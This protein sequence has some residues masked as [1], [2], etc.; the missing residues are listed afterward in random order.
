MSSGLN[1]VMLLGEVAADPELYVT[2]GG[3]A[4]LQLRLGTTE[5]YLDKDD[6]RHERTWYHAVVVLNK[7]AHA[8]AKVLHRG[9]RIFVEG[10]LRTTTFESLE[11]GAKRTKTEV[12]ADEVLYAGE[13]G[14][15][16]APANE[17][18]PWR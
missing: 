10:K 14:A 12:V 7:R 15:E 1:K 9:S 3:Q 13:R 5:S 4:V 6:V 11:G 2:R 17:V 8:L 16:P 18:I